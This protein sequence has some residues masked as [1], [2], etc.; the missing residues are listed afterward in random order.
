[1]MDLSTIEYQQVQTILASHLAGHEVRAIGSRVKGGSKP[2]SDLDI[3]IMTTP[4]RPYWLSQLHE[5]FEESDLPFTVDIMLW[6]QLSPVFRAIVE[7]Q[8]RVIQQMEY[9]PK[10]GNT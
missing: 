7:E 1:M 3:V 4:N 2:W 9:T 5:A 10:V 8:Y 6:D